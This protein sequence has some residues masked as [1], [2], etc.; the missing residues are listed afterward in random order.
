MGSQGIF[1]ASEAVREGWARDEEDELSID[2]Y[3][4]FIQITTNDGTTGFRVTNQSGATSFLVKSD[5]DGYVARNL[6]VGTESPTEKLD[7]RGVV[8]SYGLQVTGGAIDGYVLTADP[9][10]VATWQEAPGASSGI[11]TLQHRNLDQL[12][13]LIAED[14]FEEY[15]YGTG[16]RIDNIIVW[17]D[18][19]MTTKIREEQFT[20]SGNRVD[21][22][23]TIQYNAAGI[24][25]ETLIETFSYSGNKITSI[26]RDII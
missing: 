13:H 10:G 1:D 20:Y 18:S 3:N 5:G 12:V 15:I 23:I 7:V 26:D 11:T 16:N 4:A 2:G 8:R 9:T 17:T 22:A 25:V 6:G 21:T 24:A 14:S 19:G